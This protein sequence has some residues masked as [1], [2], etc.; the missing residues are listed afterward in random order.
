M[1]V[2]EIGHAS[3]YFETSDLRL[4]MDPV[5]SDPH[6]EGL[7]DITPRRQVRLEQLP[8]LDVLVISHR[9]LDHF[10][11]RTLAALPKQCQVVI[12]PDP[13]LEEYLARLGFRR[14]L[15]LA[16]FKGIT[17]G[18]TKLLAT[19]SE[20][21]VPEF[22]LV[23]SDEEHVVWNQVD[24]IVTPRTV[25]TVLR[26]VPGIDLLLPGWQPMLELN[27]QTHKSLDF[28]YERY[29]RILHNIGLTA[30]RAVAP[31]ANGFKYND[32]SEWLNHIVFPVPRARF[33]AD[34]ARVL[35]HAT[36][37]D[38]LPGDV[39][40]AAAGKVTLQ[41]NASPFVQRDSDTPADL[42]FSPTLVD[43]RLIDP[44]SLPGSAEEA[45]AATA[46]TL[47]RF[48]TLHPAAFDLHKRWG[49]VYQLT[50]VGR[51]DQTS[52]WIDFGA[53]TP[54]VTR[55]GHASPTMCT[56]IAASALLG[57]STKQLGWDYAA[58]GG[59][60][61]HTQS[62]CAVYPHGLLRPDPGTIRDPLES[63]YGYDELFRAVL[64]R[65]V[66]RWSAREAMTI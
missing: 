55:G 5:L 31:G 60:Y 2:T 16:D 15:T 21:R 49:V 11:I 32:R 29:G 56:H 40:T 27:F 24:S 34:V 36:I 39:I 26:Q 17:M 65:E 33:L 9:H 38:A 3:L 50:V 62:I 46:E 25:A 10:H 53:A 7:F 23:I 35:P 57:L 48:V 44:E 64:D 30:A 20:N 1:R 42:C 66:V 54:S 28:P 8:P 52:W 43:A 22:G 18:R 41:S 6:Q 14:V 61:R 63:V 59:F 19:R 37:L 45:G 47:E 13:L 4:L 12:P 58:I 51:D